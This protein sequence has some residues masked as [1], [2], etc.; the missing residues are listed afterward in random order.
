MVDLRQRCCRF[1]GLASEHFSQD[2]AAEQDLAGDQEEFGEEALG[3]VRTDRREKDDYKKL[4]EQLGKC[5]KL[6]H[7]QS[8]LPA[9]WPWQ[10]AATFFMIGQLCA[11]SYSAYLV[12][13]KVCVI[14]K[15]SDDEQYIWESGA[16]GSFTVQKDTEQVHGEIKRGTKITCYLKQDHSEFLEVRRLKDWVKKHSEFIGFPIELYVEKSKEKE[17][18][19][20]LFRVAAQHDEGLCQPAQMSTR[21][22]SRAASILTRMHNSF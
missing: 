20:E 1:R 4:C 5:L 22:T 13:D 14:S 2:F 19:N 21:Y 15:H 7:Q 3:Y 11:G 18:S 8:D 9:W 17:V 10:L 6:Q 12:F 16:G